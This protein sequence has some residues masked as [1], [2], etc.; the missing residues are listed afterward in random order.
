MGDPND[1]T[2]IFRWDA[3]ELNL[4][5]IE[6]YD[7]SKAWVA[8]IR[9]DDGKTACDVFIY[10]DDVRTVGPMEPECWQVW[11]M[12][13]SKLNW[14]GL[15]DA[16]RKRRPPSQ[17]PGAWAGSIVH[18]SRGQVEVMVSQERWDKTKKIIGWIQE[19]LRDH[20]SV[21][22]KSL[23]GHRAFLVYISRT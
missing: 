20:G 21:E 2:N 22:F 23:E 12:V 10:V 13:A 5:G 9:Y 14:L 17:E 7:P 11:R 1:A 3:V 15:Q 8:K 18:S 16:A 19:Q 6:G 4:P